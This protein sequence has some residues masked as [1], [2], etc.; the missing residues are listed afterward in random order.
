MLSELMEATVILTE[1]DTNILESM[2]DEDLSQLM[3]VT[4]EEM[5][6][7]DG[8]EEFVAEMA[9]VPGLNYVEERTIVKLD[10]TAKKTR[11]YKMAILQCAKEGNDPNYKKQCTL[12]KMERFLMR[13]MEKKWGTKAKARMRTMGEK[14]KGSKAEPIRKIAPQMTR[15]QRDTAKSH[16]IGAVPAKLKAET[17]T[18]MKKLES[19]IK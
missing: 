19:K 16:S 12:W 10:R 7:S 13:K 2:S 17:N 3:A 8:I 18:V 9:N 5:L 4:L 14:A 6:G 11:N 15:A 1:Q